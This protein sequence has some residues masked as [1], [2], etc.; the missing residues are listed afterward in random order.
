M[1][2]DWLSPSSS[3]LLCGSIHTLS[4]LSFPM[5]AVQHNTKEKIKKICNAFILVNYLNKNNFQLKLC[6]IWF[7]KKNIQL[8]SWNFHPELK[9]NKKFVDLLSNYWWVWVHV[10]K[11]LH[12]YYVSQEKGEK[13]IILMS[14]VQLNSSK[15]QLSW[16]KI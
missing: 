9:R 3:T 14:T 12:L 16:K 4:L 11:L 10:R 1:W 6:N 5:G 2:V 13:I 8:N 15:L 7:G